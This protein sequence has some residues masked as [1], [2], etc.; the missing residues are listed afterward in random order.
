MGQ[1]PSETRPQNKT[2]KNLSTKFLK[3]SLSLSPTTLFMTAFETRNARQE[4]PLWAQSRRRQWA[5]GRRSAYG[6]SDAESVRNSSSQRM[7]FAVHS[8]S[9]FRSRFGYTSGK[10]TRAA[11]RKEKIALFLKID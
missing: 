4:R 8:S 9:R 6:D 5:E 1:Q 2:W 11:G 10:I 3:K 7:A